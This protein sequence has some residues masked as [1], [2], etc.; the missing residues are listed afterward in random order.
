MKSCYELAEV[1]RRFEDEYID[2]H[3]PGQYRLNVLHAIRD[4]RTA[5][6]ERTYR[7]LYLSVTNSSLTI[8]VKYIPLSMDLEQPGLRVGAATTRSSNG[9]SNI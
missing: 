6:M 5:V 9:L 8:P 1:I 7:T 2:A 4:C 3:H